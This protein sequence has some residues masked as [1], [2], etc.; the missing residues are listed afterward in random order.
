MR[1]KTEWTLLF[2]ILVASL[3]VRMW[4]GNFEPRPS[5]FW[6]EQYTLDNIRPVYA[7]ASLAPVSGYYPSPWVSVPP[8][9]ALWSA[10]SARSVTGG[11]WV[12]MDP[13]NGRFVPGAYRIMRWLQA[14]YG[15]AGVL[16]IFLIG[17]RMFDTRVGLLAATLLGAMPWHIH[18]SGYIK[19]DAQLVAFV[20]LAFLA[21]LA[22]LDRPTAWR[23]GLAGLAIALAAS[24]KLTGVVIAVALGVGTLLL[25]RRE[26]TRLVLLGLSGV[27]A[28]LAFIATNPYWQG[29]LHL[30]RG[31]RRDYALR[32][33]AASPWGIPGDLI[34]QILDNFGLG[35]LAGALAIGGIATLA[36]AAVTGRGARSIDRVRI[37][38][39]LAFPVVHTAMYAAQTSYFKGNNFL[40]VL[41][42][43][44]LAASWALVALTTRTPRPEIAL[45][46]AGVAV[47]GLA[48]NAGAS[49]VYRSVT[50]ETHDLASSFIH[51]G[52]GR[53]IGRMV[54][55]AGWREAT[56]PWERR[57][58]LGEGESLVHR[59][60][61][62]DE[63][64]ASRLLMADG[65]AFRASALEDIEG[66]PSHVLNRL[67]AT[68]SP[69]QTTRIHGRGFGIRGRDLMVIARRW[70][71]RNQPGGRTFDADCPEAPNDAAC[72]LI[73]LPAEERLS[74][75]A[76]T[77]VIWPGETV[78]PESARLDIGG[79]VTLLHPT[80]KGYWL[81]DRVAAPDG[82]VNLRLP[83]VWSEKASS[84]A[85]IEC[86][87]WQPPV[88][89]APGGAP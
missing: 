32:T 72:R 81:S 50:P 55:L 60:A 71:P 51:R 38:A 9:L 22:A 42:F 44:I 74:D 75:E 45:A 24:A 27:L 12:A 20:L 11:A 33:E 68:S 26:P 21:A 64:D 10:E 19:P 88:P 58:H 43:A 65:I 87:R 37:A 57:I 36:F 52:I 31:L 3:G 67:I 15:T 39:M 83:G 34:R 49:Y 28:F 8:A 23:H 7:D 76:W 78:R 89:R 77:F 25:A 16:L 18:A 53:K 56:P 63:I 29:Y 17:R 61:S 48:A 84:Q 69:D 35:P 66:D 4:Y 41:P 2:V 46:I 1:P 54:F 70:R 79:R 14:L 85:R 13:S 59:P 5:R 80:P 6:D 62:I 82:P 30:I 86:L 73:D 47:V 40:P